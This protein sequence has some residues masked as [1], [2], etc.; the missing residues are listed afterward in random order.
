MSR[1]CVYALGAVLV[2]TSQLLAQV[3]KSGQ[4]VAVLVGINDYSNTKLRNLKCAE[5]DATDLREVLLTKLRYDKRDVYLMTKTEGFDA[6]NDSLFPTGKNIRA[7]LKGLLEDLRKEDTVLIAFSGHGVHLKALKA[8]GLHFCPS[9]TNLDKPE[10]LISISEIYAQL[11]DHCQAELK[12]LVMDACRNDPSDGRA[13]SDEKLESVTRPLI[14]KPEGGTVAFFSCSEGQKAFENEKVG[15]GFFTDSL[16][17]GLSGEAAN[18][19]GEVTIPL[20]EEFL[21]KDVTATVKRDKGLTT[22]QIPERLGDL[23]GRV[24]VA[25]IEASE[26]TP[27]TAPMGS[28]EK[29]DLLGLTEKKEPK[30]GEEREFEIFKGVRMKFCWVP[31]GEA[32]LG[33]PKAERAS[34]MKRLVELKFA[35]EGEE[36]EWL[37]SEAEEVRGKFTTKGFWLGK[38]EVTQEQWKKVMGNE[39]SHF[40]GAQL[41][42]ETVSWKDCQKFIEKCQVAGLKVKLPHED[43]WEYAC[44]GGRGNKQAFYW[45]DTLNGDKANCAKTLYHNARK[46]AL[47]QKLPRMKESDPKTTEVGSYESKAKHPWSLCD[48]HGNVWEWCDNLHSKEG[49]TRVLRG[50]SWVVNPF[51]CRAAYRFGYS[52]VNR[53]NGFGFRVCLASD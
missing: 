32:Q 38:Y 19:E 21:Q 39:P 52:P 51:G 49:T 25:K 29:K 17:R 30:A 43:E 48:R 36:P 26:T 31:A 3:P 13:G 20:L 24:L 40:K 50:G 10:T 35:K 47:M 12:I 8:K 16:I 2:L 14:P 5:K 42:V 15:R 28:P 44:R 45:G 34:V 27:K 9:D 33:S 37:K 6:K 46:G 1:F 18:K 41:P 11:K 4:K 53:G 23:R 22:R 7:N